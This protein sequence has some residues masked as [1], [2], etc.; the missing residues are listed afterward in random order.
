LHAQYPNLQVVLISVDPERDTP[1]SIAHYTQSFHPD[2]I[3]VTG[4][5]VELRKLQSQLG[6][7]AA[8]DEAAGEQYQIQ[9]TSSILLI[10]PQGKWAGIFKFGMTPQELTQSVETSIPFLAKSLMG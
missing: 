6:I 10:N 7:F 1:T 4:K 2:F 9:H 5:I 3:G 8:R